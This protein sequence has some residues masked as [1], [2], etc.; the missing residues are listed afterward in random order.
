MQ[1]QR[2]ITAKI[3]HFHASDNSHKHIMCVDELSLPSLS[4]WVRKDNVAQFI[5][6][7]QHF[8]LKFKTAPQKHSYWKWH[9]YVVVFGVNEIIFPLLFDRMYEISFKNIKCAIG[10]DFHWNLIRWQVSY[11]SFSKQQLAS[12]YFF[13]NYYF[14]ITH[15][16]VFNEIVKENNNAA[17]KT[18]WKNN[19]NKTDVF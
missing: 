1:H 9:P 2:K 10:N 6:S 18:K 7:V 16:L 14:D 13:Y 15:H 11:Q 8:N 19:E 12:D 17:V 4:F 5:M 3:L